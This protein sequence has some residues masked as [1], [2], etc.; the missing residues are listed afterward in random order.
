[1]H[2]GS[3]LLVLML[4]LIKSS[5]VYAGEAQPSWSLIIRY[6][7]GN[8]TYYDSTPRT[9]KEF[10]VLRFLRNLAAGGSWVTDVAVDCPNRTATALRQVQY[11]GQMGNGQQ[12]DLMVV[13]ERAWKK[14]R[15]PTWDKFVFPPEV[16]F[17]R[18]AAEACNVT[19]S[20]PAKPAFSPEAWMK[21]DYRFKLDL[22]KGFIQVAKE[23]SAILRLPAEY[24]LKEVIGVIIG[25]TSMDS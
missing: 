25:V 4:L 23:D 14:N 18:L 8:E 11:Q 9:Y 19:R 3:A 24:Y 17:P 7:S 22:I 21:Q 20:N 5:T 2:S 15:W 16:G 6:D 1:M 12:L 10:I 13:D